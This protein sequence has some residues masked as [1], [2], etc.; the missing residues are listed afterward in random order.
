MGLFNRFKK[1]DKKEKKPKKDKKVIPDDLE[2]DQDQ[3]IL[4]EIATNSKDRFERA[5][6]ADQITDQYVAL[7]MSKNIKDRAIRLI[8]INKVKDEDLLRDAAENS[9][10][11]DVRSFAWERLGEN[12]KSIAEIVINTKKNPNVDEIFNKITDENTLKWIAKDAQDKRYRNASVEKINDSK[13][14][15]ELVF[16]AKDSSIRKV[17]VDKDSFV[18]E[19]MLQKVAIEDKDESVKMAAVRKIKNEDNLVDIALNE[20][21][22]KIRSIIF[23]R[24]RNLTKH[25]IKFTKSRC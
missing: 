23:D 8:A 14:L 5:S 21:N 19:D 9:Q 17:C 11:Y 6:A 15:Y 22:A 20:D 1:D 13:V 2:I 25:C 18:S 12:N 10:Y 4:K 3:L 16:E 24:K 7:D